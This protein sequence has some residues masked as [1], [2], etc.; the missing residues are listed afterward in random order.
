[1]AAMHIKLSDGWKTYWRQP[2]DAGIP[3][4]ID[5][6]GSSN[7]AS[8]TLHWPIPGSFDQNGMTV[9]GYR[10]ELVLP[11]ELEPQGPGPLHLSGSIQLGVCEE[12][13]IPVEFTLD[14]AFSGAGAPDGLIAEALA[15]RPE[16]AAD[17][18]RAAPTCEARAI[19]DGL[20]VEMRLPAGEADGTTQFVI[21]P[22]DPTIWVSTPQLRK[23]QGDLVAQV[24][25]V[26]EN[27]R[28]FLLERSA[29]RLTLL[30][31]DGR[32]VE[33]LGCRG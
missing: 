23:E 33:Y 12:V 29:V 19:A 16:Q 7:I 15:N 17:L 6:A 22:G 13:C 21:E 10:D 24:E 18:G 11:F 1:M 4:V 2:G 3:P 26:P 32:A 31:A 8:Y 30:S 25:M 14:V 28:P 9:L 5:L 20:E 27:A